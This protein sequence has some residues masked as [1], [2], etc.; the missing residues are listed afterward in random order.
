MNIDD[1]MRPRSIAILGASERPSIGRA[2]MDTLARLG[3]DGD[4]YPVNPKYPSLLGKT[5]YASLRDLPKAPD[6]VAFCVSTER[7]LEG[8]RLAVVHDRWG[9][10]SPIGLAFS[11]ALAPLGRS[12]LRSAY[13]WLWAAHV[14]MWH[15]FLAA[16]PYTKAMHWFTSPLNIFFS[17]PVAPRGVPAPVWPAFEIVSFSEPCR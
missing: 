5:C 3:F 9:G 16:I 12:G 8:M 10:W 2:L 13:P 15:A 11:H 6:V 1:L 17:R 4:V 7:A 14:L